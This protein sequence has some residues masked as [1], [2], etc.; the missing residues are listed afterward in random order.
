MRLPTRKAETER[1]MNQVID[2]HLTPAKIKAMEQEL[3]NL[4]KRERRPA[5]D[6]V[7]RT[8]QMG[9]L[10]ENA[11]YQF[12]KQNLRRI[13]DRITILEERL[14]NAIPIDQS[15]SDGKI[16]IGSKVVVSVKGKQMDFEILGSVE[17]NP[18]K[19][20]I[21]YSSPLG[22]ALIGHEAGETVIVKTN[23]Q[24]LAY[25]IVSVD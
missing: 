6:E 14:K 17:S 18:F 19:G 11:G 3:E 5:A 16:R 15:V 20:R 21:S 23:N 22:A 10:S 1:I 9:D 7:A 4:V 2:N 25:D 13:N 8:A 12:A 24:E